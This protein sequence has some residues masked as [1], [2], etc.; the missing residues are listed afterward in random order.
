MK[1]KRKI[2]IKNSGGCMHAPS[3][4]CESFQRL[5]PQDVLEKIT[6]YPSNDCH[7]EKKILTNQFSEYIMLFFGLARSRWLSHNPTSAMLA[8]LVMNCTQLTP[9]TH[10]HSKKSWLFLPT[11]ILCSQSWHCRPTSSSCVVRRWG[12]PPLLDKTGIHPLLNKTGMRPPLTE[13]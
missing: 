7:F 6:I 3:K 13:N 4:Q 2:P 9:N 12:I 10:T 11:V 8:E 5:S 1:G